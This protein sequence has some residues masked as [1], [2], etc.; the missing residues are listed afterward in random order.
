MTLEEI[1]LELTTYRK[2]D[3]DCNYCPHDVKVFLESKGFTEE[4]NDGMMGWSGDFHY[5]YTKD[6]VTIRHTGS[7]YYGDSNLRI[8]H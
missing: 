8:G 3:I 6:G 1:F 4:P 7:A 2:N 5:P